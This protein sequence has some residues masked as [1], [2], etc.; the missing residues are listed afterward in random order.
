LNPPT[1]TT[2]AA[3]RRSDHALGAGTAWPAALRAA[4]DFASAIIV[5]PTGERYRAPA[6]R[7]RATETLR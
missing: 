2:G 6:V 3:P 7:Q 5:L 1:L 4:V